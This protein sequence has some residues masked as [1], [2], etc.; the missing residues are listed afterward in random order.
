MVPA[1]PSLV[2]CRIKLR[3]KSLTFSLKIRDVGKDRSPRFQRP[4]VRADAG[5]ADRGHVQEGAFKKSMPL[6]KK[7]M[8]GN[9]PLAVRDELR[10]IAFDLLERGFADTWNAR[11]VGLAGE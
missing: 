8:R 4:A 6:T 11:Q 10:A 3:A 9:L 1:R 5:V 7:S 2:R